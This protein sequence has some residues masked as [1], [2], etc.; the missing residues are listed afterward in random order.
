MIVNRELH[1]IFIVFVISVLWIL[2]SNQIADATIRYHPA[3]APIATS[4][5]WIPVLL[6]LLYATTAFYR[7][8]KDLDEGLMKNLL[9]YQFLFVLLSTVYFFMQRVNEVFFSSVPADVI[10]NVQSRYG[11][12]NEALNFS[13]LLVLLINLGIILYTVY[14]TRNFSIRY[15]FASKKKHKIKKYSFVKLI[16]LSIFIGAL[17]DYSIAVFIKDITILH[18]ILIEQIPLIALGTYAVHNL[19]RSLRRFTE[20]TRRVLISSSLYIILLIAHFILRYVDAQLLISTEDLRQLIIS[21]SGE[22][23]LLSILLYGTL[24][25]ILVLAIELSRAAVKLGDKYG[26]R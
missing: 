14:L 18:A 22:R 10:Q 5:G 21:Y 12:V 2:S 1:Y 13:W 16:L 6:I 8:Y 26:V 7:A 25:S 15:G 23:I 4:V 9:T 20:M 17:Y 3:L 19:I 11:F 24:I